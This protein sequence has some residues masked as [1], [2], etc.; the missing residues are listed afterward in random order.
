M[1]QQTEPGATRALI[2]L[3]VASAVLYEV[4][5][6][7][8]QSFAFG[9]DQQARPI[10]L[11]LALFGVLF[12]LY[13]VATRVAVQASQQRLTLP[14]AIV[15]AIIFRAI[16]LCSEPIQEVDVYRYLWDGAVTHAGVSPFGYAPQQVLDATRIIPATA[17][18]DLLTLVDLCKSDESL[19]GVLK[20]V[21]WRKVKTV[22]PPASQAVFYAVHKLTPTGTSVT[23]RVRIM[24]AALVLFDIATMFVV[25]AL[26]RLTQLPDGLLVGYAWCPLLIKEC[27]NSGH[28]DSIVVLITAVGIYLIVRSLRTATRQRAE[29]SSRVS[30]SSILAGCL[31]LALAVGAKIYPI[32]LLPWL[33]AFCW[34]ERWLSIAGPLVFLVGSWL[35]MAPMLPSSIPDR[36]AAGKAQQPGPSSGLAIFAKYWE[37]NDFLF[38]IGVENLKPT[39]PDRPGAWFVVLPN[40][41]RQQMVDWGATTFGWKRKLVPFLLTRF[42]TAA[43]FG[44]VALGLARW[45]RREDTPLIWLQAAF[46]T[47]AWFWLLGPTQ[48]P[49]YWTWTLPFLPFMRFKAWWAMSGLLFIYYLRF[50]FEYHWA[51]TPVAGTPYASVSFFDMVVTW[52]EFAPWFLWLWLSWAVDRMR[53]L[54][55]QEV[56]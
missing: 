31:G 3:A 9:A 10:L 51:H 33:I 41:W 42:L 36:A 13:L 50:W 39:Q 40:S 46:L 16:L 44:I 8:S 17:D 30:P 5:R 19:L 21:H 7:L 38:L 43:I 52:I 14:I 28:L 35:V 34:R 56:A 27:A 23:A 2:T 37:M 48:N 24:R 12:G 49:W 18:Q 22:Y 47:I 11:V 55:N 1:T 29:G 20:R 32:I 54:P 53:L 26:L 6:H 4:I 25:L 15:A 45:A